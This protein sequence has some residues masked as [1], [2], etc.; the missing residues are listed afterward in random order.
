MRFNHQTGELYVADAYFGLVKVGPNGG[1]PTQLVGAV[2]G[3]PLRF[4]DGVD[5]D[6]DTG[7]VYFTEASA[8]Y[9]IR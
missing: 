1:A 8:F 2:Q 5:V 3:R 6:P 7:M 9:Q 4:A